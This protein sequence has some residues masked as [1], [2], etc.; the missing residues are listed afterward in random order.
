MRNA[1]SAVLAAAVL[2]GCAMNYPQT[3]DEFRQQIVASDSR[4]KTTMPTPLPNT[5]PDA[6]ASNT[7]Q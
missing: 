6:S 2:S 1:I 5:V 4:F 7:R 3:R